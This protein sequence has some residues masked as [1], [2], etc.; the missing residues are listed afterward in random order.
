M[1]RENKVGE[2]LRTAST[3]GSWHR[4]KTECYSNA[5]FSVSET[6]GV[7]INIYTIIRITNHVKEEGFVSDD[8]AKVEV[9]SFELR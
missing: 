1:E 4:Q 8:A 7:M 6:S 9:E 3:L 2:R 5:A